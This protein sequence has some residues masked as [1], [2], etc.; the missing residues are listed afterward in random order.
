M[1]QAEIKSDVKKTSSIVKPSARY[2]RDKDRELVKGIFRFHEVRQHV[3]RP[4]AMT[5][6]SVGM[7]SGTRARVRKLDVRLLTFIGSGLIFLTN[8]SLVRSARPIPSAFP[9][10]SSARSRTA[11]RV[12]TGR[13]RSGMVSTRWRPITF[14][15]RPVPL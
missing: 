3:S 14:G 9:C 10:D 15:S 11:R 6:L 5:S 1:T 13:G 2:L 8:R 7:A 12:T 4:V